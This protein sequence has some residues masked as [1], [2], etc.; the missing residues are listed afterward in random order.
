MSFSSG[1][2]RT[3]SA[4]NRRRTVSLIPVGVRGG[5]DLTYSWR[6]DE[7]ATGSP[8]LEAGKCRAGAG[9]T[10]QGGRDGAPGTAR[11]ATRGEPGRND[12]E[13]LIQWVGSGA[14]PGPP[15]AP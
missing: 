8:T 4:A 15:P 14:R 7:S 9:G 1:R 5:R 3:W 13:P 6:T 12:R 2:G 10:H 11:G